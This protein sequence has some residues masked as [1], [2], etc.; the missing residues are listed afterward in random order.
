MEQFKEFEDEMFLKYGLMFDQVDYV[1]ECLQHMVEIMEDFNQKA[2][3]YLDIA[4]ETGDIE[5]QRVV[6]K[7]M[8]VASE[9]IEVMVPTA[10]RLRASQKNMEKNRREA[11][12]GETTELRQLG[13]AICH[14]AP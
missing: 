11:A 14:G 13:P 8:A 1:G 12:E 4:I 5:F 10:N 7:D 3:E 2:V 9:M 6:E